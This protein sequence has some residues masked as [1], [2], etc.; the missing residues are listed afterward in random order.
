MDRMVLIEIYGLHKFTL[1]EMHSSIS[2][3]SG[4]KRE[5]HGL[6]INRQGIAGQQ[7]RQ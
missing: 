2:I 1:I 7:L 3:K 5:S 4:T 6:S